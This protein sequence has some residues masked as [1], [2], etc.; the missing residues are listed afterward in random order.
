MFIEPPEEGIKIANK[1]KADYILVYSVSKISEIN[2]R[3]YY[4]PY[5]GGDESKIYWFLKIGGFNI[6]EYLEDDEYTPK[7]KFW[8]STFIGKL[9]P[10]ALQGYISS[11][12][13]TNQNISKITNNATATIF[14]EYK[15]GAIALY[16]KQIKY[17]ENGKNHDL[18]KQ[19]LNLVYSLSGSLTGRD[20][21]DGIVS[22]ILVFKVDNITHYTR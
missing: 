9:L 11:S 8:N 16:S 15:P 12:A 19:P 18:V 17:A 7:P 3:S 6:N 13:F 20:D 22:N 4:I 21:Q 10:F 5:G 14:H 1:L 2:N